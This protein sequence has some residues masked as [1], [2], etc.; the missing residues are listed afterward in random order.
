MTAPPT[1]PRAVPRNNIGL[2]R[3]LLALAVFFV[4]ADVLAGTDIPVPVRLAVGLFFALSGYFGWQ[5]ARAKS[6]AAYLLRRC[7]RLLLPYWAAVVFFTFALAAVSTF[8]PAAYF[9]SAQ[10]LRYLAANLLT[11]NFAQPALPGVFAGGAADGAVNGSLWF[12]KVEIAL[13]LLTPLLAKAAP[14]GREWLSSALVYAL[15]AAALLFGADGRLPEAAARYIWY[16]QMYCAGALC[17]AL[18]LC[19]RPS[20]LWWGAAGAAGWLAACAFP[21]LE[22]VLAIAPAAAALVCFG[23]TERFACLNRH[24]LS[25]AFF[26]VHFPLLQCAAQA[27]R[28]GW[29]QS[30][31]LSVALAFAASALLS[32]ALHAATERYFQRG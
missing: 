1:A 25:Y 28:E 12:V 26:L 18:N 13:A 2:L 17:A 7:R 16:L 23:C 10:W 30:P 9:G 4:H 14:R 3:Y 27:Q 6:P 21:D 5:G 15:C 19:A 24:N 29:W 22:P 32:A 11:L 31:W 20:R 8:P